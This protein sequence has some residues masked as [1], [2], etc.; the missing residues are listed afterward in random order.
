MDRSFWVGLAA[1]A[2]VGAGLLYT[3][4]QGAWRAS[5]PSGMTSQ[6]SCLQKSQLMNSLP[7]GKCTTLL[8]LM[9]SPCRLS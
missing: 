7:P 5:V 8:T 3:L 2:A 4:Q 1:G 9:K 6:T